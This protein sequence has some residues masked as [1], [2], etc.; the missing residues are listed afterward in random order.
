MQIDLSL[1]CARASNASLD[2]ESAT[3]V[4]ALSNLSTAEGVTLVMQWS[5]INRNGKTANRNPRLGETDIR[6]ITYGAESGE[7]ETHKKKDIHTG[8]VSLSIRTHVP[9]TLQQRPAEKLWN[10]LKCYDG[11]D[12]RWWHDA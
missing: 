11:R 2:S 8:S 1:H 10:G 6:E 5:N 12:F 4:W 7:P 9:L 3:W